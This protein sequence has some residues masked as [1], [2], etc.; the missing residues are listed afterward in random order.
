MEGIEDQLHAAG[1]A[2]LFKDP[3]KILLHRMLAEPKLGSNVPVA[4]PISHKRH[5]LLFAGSQQ[6]LAIGAHHAKRGHLA[7]RVESR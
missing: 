6:L 3:E 5:H 4:E 2:Q 1:D 7:N